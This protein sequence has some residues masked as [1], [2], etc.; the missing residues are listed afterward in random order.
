MLTIRQQLQQEDYKVNMKLARSCQND[1]V[2]HRCLNEVDKVAAF[3]NARLSAILLCLEG[4]MKDGNFVSIL[5]L[6]VHIHVLFLSLY[7]CKV[8]V[9]ATLWPKF[10][11]AIVNWIL[12]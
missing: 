6:Y 8:L 1:I 12:L 4:A 3:K 2:N 11:Y 5:M 7:R 9:P 10:H